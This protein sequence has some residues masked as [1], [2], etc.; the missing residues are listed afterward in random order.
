MELQWNRWFASLTATKRRL[1]L[2]GLLLG[3]ILLIFGSFPAGQTAKP[4]PAED[5]AAYT[6]QLEERTAILLRQIDGAGKVSVMISLDQG[7]TTRYQTNRTEKQREGNAEQE[8]TVVL[9]EQDGEEEA[10]IQ[11]KLQPTVRGVA[12]I[13]EGARQ[14]AVEA[15]V[16]QTVTKLFS[17]TTAQVSV[18]AGVSS[19]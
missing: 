12:V 15:A 19:N 4:S 5:L 18:V 7:T 16:L 14:P 3:M 8:E 9:Y 11:T 10:L 2:G 17:L 1:L 13:C 6:A